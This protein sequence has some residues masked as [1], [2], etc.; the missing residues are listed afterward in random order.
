MIKGRHF[1][2]RIKIKA[3]LRLRRER[4]YR[5]WLIGVELVMNKHDA[6]DKK[7]Q[8]RQWPIVVQNH[9]CVLKCK[10]QNL[11]IQ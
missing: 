8:L 7:P 3:V 4:I 1:I 9:A 10:L 5:S 2:V 6:A 11:H